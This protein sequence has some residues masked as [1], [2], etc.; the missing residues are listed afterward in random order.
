MSEFF[1]VHAGRLRLKEFQAI[2]AP[3]GGWRFPAVTP[4]EFFADV[5]GRGCDGSLSSALLCVPSQRES[6]SFPSWDIWSRNK[7]VRL[8]PWQAW[9]FSLFFHLTL[10]A[11]LII[12]TH[13]KKDRTPMV[14][15][16]EEAPAIEDMVEPPEDFSPDDMPEAQAPPE[17]ENLPWPRKPLHEDLTAEED[18]P[19]EA[20][21]LRPQTFASLSPARLSETIP[22]RKAE[23]PQKSVV[24]MTVPVVEKTRPSPPVSPPVVTRLQPQ[25]IRQACAP[26]RYPRLARRRGWEGT[27]VLEV[28]VDEEGRV[29]DVRIRKGSGHSVL[30]KAALTAVRSWR[31]TPGRTGTSPCAGTTTVTVTFE[32]RGRSVARR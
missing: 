1:P 25:P 19:E 22:V 32:L 30:D 4:S 9:C 21:T 15:R 18:R 27:V 20:P 16:W 13:E 24:P 10:F 17:P 7:S 31:F 2:S 6:F 26:A 5:P 12:P 28:R 3:M 11:T 14:I 29:V 23:P 8:E